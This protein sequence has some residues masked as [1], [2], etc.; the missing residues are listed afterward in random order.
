M[1]LTLDSR[2]DLFEPLVKGIVREGI[3]YRTKNGDPI[4]R[5]EIEKLNRIVLE[6]GFKFPDLWDEQFLSFLSTTRSH[7]GEHESRQDHHEAVE[8][9]TGAPSQELQQLREEFY[10]LH[11]Q[12]D[13]QAAG[14]SLEQLLNQLFRLFGLKPREPFRL[15]GEQIDGSFQLDDDT[16]LLEAKWESQPLSQAP[17]LVFRGKVE[18]KSLFTRGLLISIFGFSQQ[19]LD[20]IT[21]GKQPN[22]FLADGYDLTL[23]L[24][25]QAKLDDLLR[26]KLRRLC[27]EGKMF[28]SAKDLFPKS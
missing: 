24:E 7:T 17:L 5:E 11:G 19:A 18:G 8:I 12:Q 21:R 1:E 27:E 3:K 23:V 9:T 26:A 15:G 28:V 2:R 20:A 6:I 4:S 10:S 14:L 16:Y 22:F 25:G 13:R